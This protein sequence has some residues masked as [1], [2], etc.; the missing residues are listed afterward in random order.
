[1]YLML[2]Q[3]LTAVSSST[4]GNVSFVFG[5]NVSRGVFSIP[6]ENDE[7]YSDRLVACVR[8]GKSFKAMSLNDALDSGSSIIED[9]TGSAING[10]RVVLRT[11]Q[12]LNEDAKR[13]WTQTC[14][15]VNE[16]LDG[17]FHSCETLGYTNLTQDS[18]RIMEGNTLKNIPNALPVLIMPFWD[19]A[20]TA[21]SAV[22]AWDGHACVFRLQGRYED[23]TKTLALLTGVGKSI[24]EPR[25]VEWLDRPGGRWKNGW[26]EDTQGMRWYSDIVAK[27]T[28]NSSGLFPRFFNPS[29][30]REVQCPIGS[31]CST[32]YS[33][34][35]WTATFAILI[36]LTTETSIAISNGSRFGFFFYRSNGQQIVTCVYDAATLISNASVIVLLWRWMIAMLT[37][38]HGYYKN[39]SDWYNADLG[40]I[41]HASSFL[42]LPI[43]MAPRL[44]MI[45]TVFYTIGCSIEGAQKALSESW[46]VMYPSI[47]DLVLIYASLLNTIARFFRRRVRA[48]VFPIMI[49]ALS[50]MQYCR[51]RLC[52]LPFFSLSG[53][54]STIIDSAEYE[55][56]TPFDMLS[57]DVAVRMG[58]NAPMILWTKLLIL[59]LSIFSLLLP[60]NMTE[61]CDQ[62]GNPILS[63]AEK[64]LKMRTNNVGGIGRPRSRKAKILSSYEVLRLGY[65]VFGGHYLMTVED[66]LIVTTMKPA[67][68]LY[69][70]W[71]HRVM[72]FK[73][74]KVE[75]EERLYKLSS[76][77]QLLSVHDPVFDA[78]PFWDIDARPL[79]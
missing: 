16:T 75:N 30:K 53:R 25:T 32:T 76:Y 69:S 5:Q 23:S 28:T 24:R 79:I 43:A 9:S 78:I 73:V 31:S 46:F 66:W 11:G 13:Q 64:I 1:M 7:P 56:L 67:R 10:Y 35:T 29:A 6:G 20:L 17:I 68:K 41:S 65:V 77:G 27:E 50:T 60:D 49:V 45:L 26:Y 71:N 14:R 70:L 55:K 48:W 52:A 18:L 22:P 51:H 74:S 33:S 62:S 36:R 3:L 44:K 57:H 72:V 38:H 8:H 15:L 39:V 40:S 54:L 4:T 61:L 58:G 12:I 34:S 63:E 37:L 21:R 19:N 59:S 2:S 42:Y 47:V